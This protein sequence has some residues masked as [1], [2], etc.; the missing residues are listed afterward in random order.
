VVSPELT[1]TGLG[2]IFKENSHVYVGVAE[3]NVI[4]LSSG[5]GDYIQGTITDGSLTITLETLESDSCYIGFSAEGVIFFM[6]KATAD[7]SGGIVSIAYNTNNFELYTHSLKGSDM[8]LSS[9]MSLQT[10]IQ[11]MS[12]GEMNNYAEWKIGMK[13]MVEEEIGDKYVDLDNVNILDIALYKNETCTLQFN[14]SD[15]VGPNTVIYTKFS[16]ASMM[17]GGDNDQ[18]AVGYIKGTV[19]FINKRE[20]AKIHIFAVYDDGKYVDDI[21]PNRYP[22]VKDNGSFSL[23]FTQ[24]FLTALESGSQNIVFNLWIEEPGSGGGYFKFDIDNKTLTEGSLDGSGNLNVTLGTVT[25]ASTTITLSGTVS[26]T[27]NEAAVPYAAITVVNDDTNELLGHAKTQS[28]GSNAPWSLILPA[29][30]SPTTIRFDVQG[31][32]E[33]PWDGW[34]FAHQTDVTVSDVHNTDVPNVTI[35]LGNITTP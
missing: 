24:T 13:A 9:S 26:L 30:I 5:P 16:L 19:S 7:F 1:I 33:E 29:F 25:L 21:Y 14:D 20:G 27:Y 11:G 15:T 17:G 8:G 34:L 28:S 2:G 32:S 10:I 6:S 35:D 18:H 12:E 31:F 4:D 23:P 22:D 3:S